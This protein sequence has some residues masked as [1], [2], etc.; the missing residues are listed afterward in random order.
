MD[1]AGSMGIGVVLGM[2]IKGA[3]GIKNLTKDFSTLENILSKT[4]IGIKG[5]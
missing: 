5:F 4:K 3:S 1:N 2:M